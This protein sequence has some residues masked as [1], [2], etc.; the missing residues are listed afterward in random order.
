MATSNIAAC[1]AVYVGKKA[2]ANG[3][4]YY[5]RTEDVNA[6]TKR[7]VIYEHATHNE[8]EFYEDSR[9]DNFK[10][11]MPKE[12]LRFS[13]LEDSKLHGEGEYPYGEAGFNELGVSVSATVTTFAGEAAAKA[14]PSV[15]GGINEVVLGH[16]LLGKATSARHGI[17]YLGQIM[18]EYGASEQFLI[19]IADEEEI[20]VFEAVSGHQWA[21]M[22]LPEDKVSVI[23]NHI[24]MGKVDVNDHE[25]YMVSEDLVKLAKDNGFL[26][27]E[28]GMINVM[29]TYSDPFGTYDS[30]R[31]YAGRKFFNPELD[32][33]E[34]DNYYE[35][36]FDSAKKITLQDIKN[37]LSIRY[38]D[39]PY[40]YNNGIDENNFNI[41]PIGVL[42]QAEVHVFEL[43]DKIST[44]WQCM[45]PIEFS[46]FVPFYT[47]IMS[48]T[49]KNMQYYDIV[50]VQGQYDWMFRK[51]STLC[52]L[53]RE[54]YGKNVR[55]YWD[56]YQLAL[57]KANE[58]VVAKMNEL[59]LEDPKAAETKA[60]T[61]AAAIA[62]E[63]SERAVLITNELLYYMTAEETNTLRA[64]ALKEKMQ[65][66]MPSC[67]EKGIYTAYNFDMEI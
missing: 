22:K 16:V 35:M 13:A 53:N 66:F 9:G 1:T 44:Q 2:S 36:L 3:H 41:R 12:T 11:P 5:G 45:G 61:L 19:F 50:P 26:V 14:D 33:N 24:I 31:A 65:P 37:L 42:R 48:E 34:T 46:T 27:E 28:D 54:M 43:D 51:L 57:I 30:Y 38:E 17:E 25:N 60:N 7:F 55:T 6:S 20:W 47:R 10:M 32:V 29:K 62:K 56:N 52:S 64:Y 58:E 40:S 63:A 15:K 39:K 18:K 23:P 59:Y 67:L 49:P 8:G 4:A 21:A